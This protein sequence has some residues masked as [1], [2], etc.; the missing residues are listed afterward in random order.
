M[1]QFYT[2]NGRWR[3]STL[4]QLSFFLTVVVSPLHVFICLRTKIEPKSAI[5]CRKR[6]KQPNFKIFDFFENF[7]KFTSKNCQPVAENRFFRVL[8]FENRI[9]A[10]LVPYLV[11]FGRFFLKNVTQWSPDFASIH[12]NWMFQVTKRFFLGPLKMAQNS[13]FLPIFA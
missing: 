5:P 1:F 10:H 12:H 3:I 11:K 2:V 8:F 9:F 13:C 4:F 6:Q 7:R